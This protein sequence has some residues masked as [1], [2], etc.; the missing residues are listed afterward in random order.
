MRKITESSLWSITPMVTA[1]TTVVALAR[2]V[3]EWGVEVSS[4]LQ[5]FAKTAQR[6]KSM[7]VR[8]PSV[9]KTNAVIIVAIVELK[10]S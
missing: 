3:G 7:R 6:R 4:L 1:A 8:V 9:A 2:D 5:C 10:G